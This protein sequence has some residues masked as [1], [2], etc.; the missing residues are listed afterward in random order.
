MDL[1]EKEIERLNTKMG[2]R[3][4]GMVFTRGHLEVDRQHLE[5]ALG[6][7]RLEERVTGILKRVEKELDVADQKIGEKLRVLDMD[8]DGVVSSCLK[9]FVVLVETVGN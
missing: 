5:E 3:G 6:Q 1:V 7:K 4:V 8:N 9:G 2:G